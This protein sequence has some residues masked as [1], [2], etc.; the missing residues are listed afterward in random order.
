[1]LTSLSVKCQEDLYRDFLNDYLKR[2]ISYFEE[3]AKLK[4]NQMKFELLNEEFNINCDSII[5][6]A[7]STADIYYNAINKMYVIE[8]STTKKFLGTLIMTY[9]KWI[10]L[11]NRSVKGCNIVE[12]VF[13]WGQNDLQIQLKKEVQKNV[14]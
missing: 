10:T 12:Q 1:M 13:R 7:I 5:K 4:S 9:I 8:I 11:G 2:L 6:L 3:H 14:D